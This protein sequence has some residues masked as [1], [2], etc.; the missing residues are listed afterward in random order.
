MVRLT[1]KEEKMLKWKNEFL[2]SLKIMNNEQL[3]EDTLALAGGDDYDGCF[4]KAGQWRYD[5]LL[6]ELEKRLKV[7]G[8]LKL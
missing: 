2:E 3:L 5:K 7:S 1:K 8:F 6:E 4:T